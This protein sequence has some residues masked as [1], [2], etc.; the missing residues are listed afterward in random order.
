MQ[1]YGLTRV[2]ARQARFLIYLALLSVIAGWKFIPRPW[3]PRITVATAHYRIAS[4]ATPAET[5]ETA[6]ALELLYSAYSNRFGGGNRFETN[7]PPLR[8]KLYR[9]RKEF[10]RINPGLGWAEAFY[11][12][13]YCRA[14]VAEEGN[15]YHWML[16]E[17]V[18]QLN[19]EV[20]HLRLAKWL[21]EGLAAYFA[22]SRLTSTGI[23]LGAIDPDTYPVRQ[24]DEIAEAPG[25]EENLGNGSVIPLR[26]VITNR[27]GPSVNRHF[28]LYYLHWWTLT[29]FLFENQKHAAAVANLVERGGGLKDVERIVGPCDVVQQEWH[30][31]V[32]AVKKF[33]ARPPPLSEKNTIRK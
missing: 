27:G 14:Y 26:A 22:T 13:P 4:S 12:A 3:H 23:V 17:A 10:R 32:R 1:R 11:R 19:H 18:H 15:R 20:A 21:E 29:H 24:S 8:V 7:H 2:T 30:D 16:H 9:D 28:N 5:E 31:H 33:L 6:R 25:L